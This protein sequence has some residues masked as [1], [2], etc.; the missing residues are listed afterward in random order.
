VGI[1]TCLVRVEGVPM[2]LIANN[3]HHFAGAIDSPASDKAARFLQVR[4]MPSCLSSWTNFS[5]F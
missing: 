1:I 4:N 2:G 3:P 5:L